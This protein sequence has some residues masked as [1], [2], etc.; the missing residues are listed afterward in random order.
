MLKK[1][2]MALAAALVFAAAPAFADEPTLH[3]V[4]QAAE[5]G[6][7]D[8]AQSMMREVLQAHPNSGKAH[9]VEAELLAKAG[10]LQKAEAELATAERLSPGLP[11]AS[12]EAVQNLRRRLGEGASRSSA[13]FSDPRA[14]VAAPVGAGSGSGFPW[15]WLALGGGLIAFIAWASRMMNRRAATPVPS[16]ASPYGNGGTM[17]PNY[18][19]PMPPYGG[20]AMNAPGQGLGSSM[21]GGLATGAAVG[22]GIAAG[23]ALF[24]RMADG[25]SDGTP[26][27]SNTDHRASFIPGPDSANAGYDDDLGGNDF[28]ISDAS[29]WDD[30]SGSDWS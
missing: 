29:S 25:R 6:K 16:S 24:H 18:N 5:A 9:F 2:L 14:A 13:Q 22:A 28:G 20:G 17:T 30:G 15:G 1:V 27:S 3:Q 23:E 8:Q 21:L 4:Y 7:L 19:A 26:L 10:Q 12:S 11:F